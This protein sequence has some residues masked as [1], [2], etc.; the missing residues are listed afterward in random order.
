MLPWVSSGD[1]VG[2]VLGTVAQDPRDNTRK[3]DSTVNREFLNSRSTPP[4]RASTHV[5]GPGTH[6]I[7]FPIPQPNKY[8]SRPPLSLPFASSIL[9]LSLSARQAPRA[10]RPQGARAEARR[11]QGS[12]PRDLA[13]GG[14]GEPRPSGSARRQASREA[15]RRAPR[16]AA[17]ERSEGSGAAA[18]SASGGGAAEGGERRGGGLRERRRSGRRGAPRR[19]APPPLS[20]GPGSAPPGT[21]AAAGRR[22]GGEEAPPRQIQFFFAKI[23]QHFFLNSFDFSN[24]YFFNDTKN[25]FLNFSCSP[26][27]FLEFFFA[28]PFFCF[29]IFFCL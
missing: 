16:A 6:V 8:P 29:E 20:G 21:G 15:R 19:R 13:Q 12:S 28:S 4:T 9:S 27:F 18:G 1:S 5:V 23:F 10:P 22:R 17:A 26:I 2:R 11:R 7:S 25:N 24:E 14:G 3:A